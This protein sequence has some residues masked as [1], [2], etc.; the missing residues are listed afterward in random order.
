VAVGESTVRTQMILYMVIIGTAG[1]MLYVRYCIVYTFNDQKKLTR[2]KE[3][4]KFS[5]RG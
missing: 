3:N 5:N 2:R 4:L 1:S